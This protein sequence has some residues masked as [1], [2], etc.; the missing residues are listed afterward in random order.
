MIF[1]TVT[2]PVSPL[3]K[4]MSFWIMALSENGDGFSKESSQPKLTTNSQNSGLSRH[5]GKEK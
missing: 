3:L 2:L 5:F 4:R 1:R